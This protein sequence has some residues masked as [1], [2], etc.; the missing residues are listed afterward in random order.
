MMEEK[1]IRSR[2]GVDRKITYVGRL[3]GDEHLWKVS[4]KSRIYRA[5]GSPDALEFVDFEGG[6]F[7]SL[8][9]EFAHCGMVTNLSVP[10]NE[11]EE[12]SITVLLTT[13]DN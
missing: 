9:E 1:S 10:Q 8:G 7:I 2:Y 3:G 6:P 4:G 11:Q 12:G 13:K 5:G